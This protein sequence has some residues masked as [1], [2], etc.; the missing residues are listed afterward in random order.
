MLRAWMQE[1]VEPSPHY[2]ERPGRWVAERAWPPV[3]AETPSVELDFAGA[4]IVG[5]ERAGLD[6][7]GWCGFG[8]PADTP[9][10]QRAEDGL[11]LCYT[12]DPLPGRLEILGLPEVVLTLSADRPRALVCVRLCDVAEDGASLLVTRGLLNLTHRDSHE[13][14]E[15]LG[16]GEAYTVRVRLNSI[17]HAFLPG[18][19]LRVAVSPTYW[20]WAWPSPEPV[21]LTLH[22]GHLELPVRSERSEDAELA[23]FGDAEGAAPFANE[24]TPGPAA[25]R[26]LER[27][28]AAGRYELTW[29]QDFRHGS[30]R[31]LADGLAWS[32]GGVDMYTIVEGDPLSAATRSNWVETLERDDWRIRIETSSTL[33]ADE[34]N[35]HITNAVDAYEGNTRVHAATRTL[36]VPRDLV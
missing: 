4:S 33:S 24:F 14:P 1:T 3:T 36:T 19:R 26:S 12:S 20:P 6:A 5:S 13:E 34:E 25:G 18:R 7:G 23:A 29:G 9:P 21:T 35:F 27:D 31:R 22:A 32:T 8:A 2:R 17:A 28:V 11:S 30:Y 15:P 10:D 16:P